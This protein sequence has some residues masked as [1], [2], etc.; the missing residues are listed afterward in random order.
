MHIT[1]IGHFSFIPMWRCRMT[2]NVRVHNTVN[3]L[4]MCRIYES[5]HISYVEAISGQLLLHGECLKR[6]IEKNRFSSLITHFSLMMIVDIMQVMTGVHMS[7]VPEACI[8]GRDKKLHPT[9]SVACDDFSQPLMAASGTTLLLYTLSRK[10]PSRALVIVFTF[11]VELSWC[12]YLYSSRLH[13]WHDWTGVY[14]ISFITA[15]LYK[16]YKRVWEYETRA[17]KIFIGLL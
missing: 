17:M 8:N 13:H 3:N 10:I 1:L 6:I 9:V 12:I 2:H 4:S 7:V 16:L 14:M 5:G 15:I 11:S